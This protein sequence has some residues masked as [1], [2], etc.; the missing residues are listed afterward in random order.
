MKK[1]IAEITAFTYIVS[2]TLGLIGYLQ[3][4]EFDFIS[5][6]YNSLRLFILEFDGSTNNIP[7]LLNVSRFLSPLVLAS[8]IFLALKHYFSDLFLRF[9][10]KNLQNHTIVFCNDE[11]DI[12]YLLQM[13]YV[14]ACC[15]HQR[16]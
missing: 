6:C 4:N 16:I 9:R 15:L 5:C 8:S 12:Y 13:L 3:T 1:Y 11:S 2:F 7:F 14:M 10:I